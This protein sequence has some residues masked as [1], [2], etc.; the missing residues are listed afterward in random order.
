MLQLYKIQDYGQATFKKFYDKRVYLKLR[1]KVKTVAVYKSGGGL[2]D[3]AQSILFFRSFKQMFP[4]AKI[5]YLGLYQRPRCDT[6]F[7]NI[8]YIDE[9][10]EYMR[11]G[12]QRTLRQ[13]F[14]FLK[15]YFRK[16]DLIVDTQSKFA[17][18]FYVWLLNPRYFLS[19]NPLFSSWRFL[20]NPKMKVHV[21]AKMLSLVRTLGF[22]KIDFNP[23]VDI[24]GEYLH[25]AQDYLKDFSGP[26]ISILPG[27][28]HPY[29]V[30]DKEKFAAL[31][32]RFYSMGYQVI[33]IG[34]EEER[35][36]LL[37]IAQM[38][39]NKPIIPQLEEPKFGQ[40]PIY[41][42][43]LFKSSALAVG[44]DCGGLHLAAL[45]GCLV[46]GVFGPTNPVKSGPLGQRNVVIYKGLNCSPCRM[47][48]CEIEHRCLKEITPDQLIE[49]S[50]FILNEATTLDAMRRG[51]L[52]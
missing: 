6:L 34:A 46:V 21:I 33:L 38:M 23:V 42:I 16:F 49:A 28:G 2:G 12:R 3:L 47:R 29:K 43:G 36:L 1:C 8:P 10:V 40:D 5:I 15:K 39:Q 4:Q 48:Q 27:A 14:S 17:P 50:K 32:D 35:V 45:A 18:S 25:L 30:W 37:R 19:R 13:Y 41:S 22:E 20:L 31:A 44:C 52:G 7:S 24:P 11:P 51:S 26:F 9:Y